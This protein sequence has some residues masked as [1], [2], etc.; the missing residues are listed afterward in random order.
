M[1]THMA[2]AASSTSESNMLAATAVL[3]LLME[4]KGLGSEVLAAAR[5]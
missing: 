5:S 1:L 3:A 2:M 4:Y